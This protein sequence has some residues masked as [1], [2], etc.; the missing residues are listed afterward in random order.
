[1]EQRGRRRPFT[2]L[3]ARTSSHLGQLQDARGTFKGGFG[4]HQLGAWLDNSNEALAM[5]LRPGNAG[6]N[7]AADHLVVL[8]RPSPRVRLGPRVGIG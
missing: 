5:V 3:V 2:D 4:H 8:E 6:S 7:T 1:L